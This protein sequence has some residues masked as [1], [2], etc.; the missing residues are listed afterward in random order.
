[1]LRPHKHVAHDL[2]AGGRPHFQNVLGI[3][4]ARFASPWGEIPLA[5]T[6]EP[7]WITLYYW[8]PA[9]ARWQAFRIDHLPLSVDGSTPDAP[10]AWNWSDRVAVAASSRTVHLLFKREVIDNG[11]ARTAIVHRRY[12]PANPD[13]AAGNHRLVLAGTT[14]I[15]NVGPGRELGRGLWAGCTP[16]DTLVVL[17]P[18]RTTTL[19]QRGEWELQLA[20]LTLDEA[21]GTAAAETRTIGRGGYDFDARLDAK[22]LHVVY[23]ETSE[24][25]RM[26]LAMMAGGRHLAS[27]AAADEFYQ[28]L[29][30]ARVDVGTMAVQAE[31]LPG[32]EHPQIQRAQPLLVTV[33]RPHHLDVAL[34]TPI[35]PLPPRR[36]G[37]VWS[38]G[39]VDKVAFYREGAE[40]YR[41]TLLTADSRRLPRSHAD[42]SQASLL[43]ED[44]GGLLAQA[45]SFATCPVQVLGVT[46][47]DKGL[48]LDLLHHRDLLGLYRTRL[49]TTLTDGAIAVTDRSFEVWDIGHGPIDDFADLA[50]AARA[51]NQ[52]FVPFDERPLTSAPRVGVPGARADDTIG[53]H[54]TAD[55]SREPVGLFAYTD[56][57]DGGLRV[58]YAPDIPSPGEPPPIGNEKVLRPEQV[59][60]PSIPCDV[61]VEFAAAD[62]AP[63]E[64]PA[65]D[66]GILHT[67][68]SLGSAMEVPL[69]FLLD[70]CSIVRESGDAPDG[71]A[72]NPADGLTRAELQAVDAFRAG[73]TPDVV[74]LL[75]VSDGSQAEVQIGPGGLVAGLDL[76]LAATVAGAGPTALW[77]AIAVDDV[78]AGNTGPVSPLDPLAFGV[79]LVTA[80]GNPA[81]LVLPRGGAWRLSVFFPVAGAAG[82]G[83]G[84]FT[85]IDVVASTYDLLTELYDGISDGEWHRIG[86]LEASLFRYDMRYG[87]GAIGDDPVRIRIAPRLFRS[88][89]VRFRGGGSGQGAVEARQV[90][91]FSSDEVRLRRGLD[92]LFAVDRF[93]VTLGYGRAFTPGMLLRDSR[94]LAIL[95][96]RPIDPAAETL[97]RTDPERH[98]AIGAKPIGDA[99]V[100]RADVD[101]GVSM[102]PGAIAVS[103]IVAALALIGATALVAT[104]V[105]LVA[106]IA[107]ATAVGIGGAAIAIVLAIVL[108]VVVATMVPPA[109]EGFAREQ[110]RGALT[111]PERLAQL[112]DLAIIR[113][114]GEGAAESLARTALRVARDQGHAVP[115]PASEDDEGA[116]RDRNYGQLFQMVFVSDGICRV[117]LRIE[118]CDPVRLPDVPA[119]GGG[120]DDDDPGLPGLGTARTSRQAGDA[121]AARA[122]PDPR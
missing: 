28:P 84:A 6:T 17:Y 121:P 114:A 98:A 78:P 57:G 67:R 1:M 100:S 65:Y 82:P 81:T 24:A 46:R 120:G 107:A 35:L 60:G 63:A 108:A 116:G 61:W 34:D 103:A 90:M 20:R 99:S 11:T 8:S 64:V 80:A 54:L 76:T 5:A 51:E 113:Y 37:V 19:L 85:D 22:T 68:R 38:P 2:L 45:S 15:A 117:L 89:E 52:Q 118:D 86:D 21:S 96:G 87:V 33:D 27:G 69:D 48:V 101:I 111:S 29:R 39:P 59:T 42:I 72:M 97:A 10:S 50:P 32:G 94:S 104:I 18:R 16:D 75:E 79:T 58:I 77:T 3:G 105:A 55:T 106:G 62:W 115:F 12:R 23:R 71:A 14:E 43:F 109:V 31:A 88:T 26:P 92:L 49:R 40:L 44:R 73:L 110:V 7:E 13:P 30:W 112:N 70:A 25:F 102:T 119:P 53:G 9:D 36:P 4:L 122:R 83:P 56:L 47:D 66:V 93:A 41:G 95:D 91:T 74:R